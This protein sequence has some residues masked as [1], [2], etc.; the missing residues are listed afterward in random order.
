MRHSF[1]LQIVIYM[2]IWWDLNKCHSYKILSSVYLLM[3]WNKCQAYRELIPYSSLKYTIEGKIFRLR[4]TVWWNMPFLC[5]LNGFVTHS[6]WFVTQFRKFT[7]PI[8]MQ[9][10]PELTS[11]SDT[12]L[13]NFSWA[14]IWAKSSQKFPEQSSYMVD[15]SCKLQN[16]EDVCILSYLA[17]KIWRA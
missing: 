8:V 12:F 16:W 17:C 5:Y 11:P 10:L 15:C 3:I 7:N 2:E 13:H 4:T 1:A 6:A 9:C 14:Q